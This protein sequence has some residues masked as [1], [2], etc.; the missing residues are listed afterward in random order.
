MRALIRVYDPDIYSI[1]KLTEVVVVVVVFV[2]KLAP[3]LL[4]S[5]PRQQ[6]AG[7][8]EGREVESHVAVSTGRVCPQPCAG[9]YS[10]LLSISLGVELLNHMA[11]AF[12]FLKSCQ[13]IFQSTHTVFRFHQQWTVFPFLPRPRQHCCGLSLITVLLLGVK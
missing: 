8:R 7:A 13:I 6:Q 5:R 4:F 1:L 10:G 11:T 9:L 2:I 3:S 12:P